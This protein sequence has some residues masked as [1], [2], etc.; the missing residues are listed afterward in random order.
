VLP[1]SDK[2]KEAKPKQSAAQAGAAAPASATAARPARVKDAEPGAKPRKR[3]EEDDD[4]ARKRRR[5]ARDLP[6]EPFFKSL[7]VVFRQS[8]VWIRWLF[9]SGTAVV[10]LAILVFLMTLPGAGL[11]ARAILMVFLMDLVIAGVWSVYLFITCVS[12]ALDTA[13]GKNEITNWS[14]VSFVDCIWEGMWGVAAVGFSALPLGLIVSLLG[15]PIILAVPLTLLGM[16][17]TFPLV[18]LSM[19]AEESPFMPFSADVW[20]G[21]FQHT[22][23]WLQFFAA[24]AALAVIAFVS[25]GSL[26]ALAV[27]W[28]PARYAVLPL[29]AAIVVAGAMLYFRLL[30]RLARLGVSEPAREREEEE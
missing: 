8:D 30:G 19:F 6:N 27:L 17:F 13:E 28:Q 18:I 20:R 15:V 10:P 23:A 26:V 24:A 25:M 4:Q 9:F 12:I 2:L 22:M 7:L 1:L 16:F 5:E 21:P 3:D 29:L 11:L 14:E